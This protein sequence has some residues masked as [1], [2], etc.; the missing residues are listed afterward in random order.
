MCFPKHLL[1]VGVFLLLCIPLSAQL[2]SVTPKI[3]VADDEV[4]IIFDAS[5][6]NGVLKD[7][8]GPV[9]AHTGVIIGTADEPS[10]WRYV[11]GEWG[12]DDP[13]MKMESLGNNRYRIQFRIREFYGIPEEETFLQMAFVFRNQTGSLVAKDSGDQDIFYPKLQT[14]EHGLLEIADSEGALSLGELERIEQGDDGSL[15][16]KDGQQQ[17]QIRKC[18]VDLH[19]MPILE[20]SYFPDS[21][22]A[23]PASESAI[24]H[25]YVPFQA[26]EADENGSYRFDLGN[27]Y[28]LS[29]SPTPIR[30]E[31][32][33]AG[34]PILNQELGFFFQH[35][36]KGMGP[37]SGIRFSLQ[38]EEHL[39]G[40]G[41]R[42]IPAD[43]RGH[44]L[45]TYNAPS[46]GY[47][48]GEEDVYLS[49]PYLQSS[50]GYGLLLDNYQAGYL[51]LGKSTNNILECAF[52]GQ[53]LRYFLI[54]S[55]DP[56]TITESLTALTGRQD[57]PP[58]WALGYIQSRY[59]YRTQAEL[60]SIVDATLAAGYPLDAVPLDLYWFGGTGSMGDLDWDTVNWPDP[61]AMIDGLKAE[62]VQPILITETYFVKGTQYFDELDDGSLFAKDENDESYVIPDFWAGEAALL[63][64]FHPQAADWFW[65]KYQ[66][67]IELGVEGWWCDSGEPENHPKKMIHTRG[68]AEQV[69]NL[70]AQYWAKLLYE[71]FTETYPNKRL[72]NLM[73][74]GFAG[75]QRYSTFPWSG[76]V[77]RSWGAFRA[78]VPI[79]LGT[80]L[81]G[82][83][84]IHSDLGGFTG[85]PRD[86]ELLQRWIQMGSF[87]PIMRVHGD[88]SGFEPEPIFYSKETQEIARAAIQLRYQ[89][90]PYNYTLAWE[91]HRLGYPML[92][93]LFFHYPQDSNTLGIDDQFLWGEH[94]LIAPV[95]EK[96][97]Q[98]RGVYLPQGGWI[99]MYEGSLYEGG[100]S[101]RIDL[102]KERIPVFVKAGSIIPLA[103]PMQHTGQYSSDSLSLQVFV[104]DQQE[105]VLQ[106]LYLDDGQTANP[107]A[108]GSY[109]L[110]EIS[111]QRSKEKLT[112]V[113]LKQTH[114]TPRERSWTVKL[115]TGKEAP[116]SIKVGKRKLK[117][118]LN[119]EEWKADPEKRF[120]WIEE[121]RMAYVSV[122][123]QGE[124]RIKA[125]YRLSE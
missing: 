41:S 30:L 46:Y 24:K 17:L 10:G 85:G 23:L 104:S 95:L 82:V 121:S 100:R 25:T 107:I 86:E 48:W 40:T 90:L 91:N 6:G 62:G 106:T 7:H 27:Q 110:F 79:M 72:F 109:E 76:D 119:P 64:V 108:K 34:S 98:E 32:S 8:T 15:I 78:Q 111:S 51:D 26:P 68:K 94:M 71:K 70:Y 12:T 73:R 38:E 28:E 56:A 83:G 13:R 112:E 22:Q 67:Q 58:I 102:S 14:Y 19:L 35:D 11:Q 80:G 39:Y 21:E 5:R 60:D 93:P 105:D 87:V 115:R 42:A 31:L 113:L 2:L 18:L 122:K 49:I 88:A 45:Y 69:H 4:S 92:R 97:L 54:A 117:A 120:W 43:R 123:W 63:D 118:V 50:Q 1:S 37:L 16:L 75:M 66:R 101:Y 44:R 29:I 52:K 53:G 55:P 124:I 74:S 125:K 57:M 96:G 47:T 84:Y 65:P 114:G 77:T 20:V 33:R 89:L 99:E 116:K 9:Y 103:P 36:S 59:G 81:S 3:P 61:K